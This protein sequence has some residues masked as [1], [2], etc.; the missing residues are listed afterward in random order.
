MGS[1][2]S[3]DTFHRVRGRAQLGGTPRG[4]EPRSDPWP[5]RSMERRVDRL[6]PQCPRLRPARGSRSRLPAV[7]PGVGAR[8][9]RRW[10]AVA[11]GAAFGPVSA[12]RPSAMRSEG[13]SGR[14][15]EGDG[16]SGGESL[17]TALTCPVLLL[18]TTT[19]S[20]ES[21]SWLPLGPPRSRV[22]ASRP[23]ADAVITDR[24]P[25]MV[26]GVDRRSR[27]TRSVTRGA[28]ARCLQ[29][30]ACCDPPCLRTTRDASRGPMPGRRW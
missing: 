26:G 12:R 2:G 16:S 30:A 1:I 6:A 19:D 14:V 24:P 18:R 10:R 11:T 7:K 9:L 28:L 21:P 3:A 17:R 29:S 20:A 25:A 8:S 5:T 15:E 27:G 22:R 23:S 4:C 13:S